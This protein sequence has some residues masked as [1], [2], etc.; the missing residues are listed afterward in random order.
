MPGLVENATAYA[1]ISLAAQADPT[2][3][4]GMQAYMKTDMPF[5][6]VQHAAR[7]EVLK[8]LRTDFPPADREE[9]EQLV[10]ALWNLPHREERY[11]AL[12]VA[13]AHKKFVVPASLPLYRR[14]ITEGAW[15][16]LVDDVATHL[17]RDLVVGFPD[18]TWPE[19]ERWVDDE[20]MWL[21]RSALLCQIGA[22][23]AT[24]SERLFRFC[25]ALAHEKE[26]FI[27]KAIG[28]ALRDYAW[29]DPEAVASFVRQFGDALSPLS[30]REAT[31]HIGHLVAR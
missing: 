28:W 4:A 20:E 25:L 3:A 22:K 15:W 24:D 7:T 1:A 17:V 18:Q 5:Y 8:R 13:R 19:V 9:Y 26:F 12:G 14:L 11:L 10:L 6:G 27:R 23:T 29:V 30:Y 2:K 21:R 16:D 31:K